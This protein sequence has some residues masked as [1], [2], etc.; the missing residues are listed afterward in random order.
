MRAVPTTDT[1][2]FLCNQGAIVFHPS[3]NQS[4]CGYIYTLISR[5]RPANE[6]M[7]T[8]IYMGQVINDNG[9][10]VLLTR[11]DGDND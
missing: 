5:S 1:R 7:Y 6:Y 3:S 8:Y 4:S 2:D 9:R 10:A 11:V